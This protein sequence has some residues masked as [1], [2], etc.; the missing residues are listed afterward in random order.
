MK[1]RSNKTKPLPAPQNLEASP[2]YSA[3]KAKLDPVLVDL[4]GNVEEKKVHKCI[5]IGIS[6]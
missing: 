1:T 2:L 3:A 4:M 5:K 6:D